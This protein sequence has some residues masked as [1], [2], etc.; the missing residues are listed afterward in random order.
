MQCINNL[1]VLL[2]IELNHYL[3]NF[4]TIITTL[5]YTNFTGLAHADD[6]AVC[7]ESRH[8]MRANGKLWGQ[9]VDLHPLLPYVERYRRYH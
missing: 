2:L 4:R 3:S 8:Y 5:R 6:V 9:G 1:G 7:K